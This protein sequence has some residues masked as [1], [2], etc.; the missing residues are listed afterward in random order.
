MGGLLIWALLGLNI[1]FLDSAILKINRISNVEVFAV[2]KPRKTADWVSKPTIRVCE[3]SEVPIFR[4]NQAVKY[5]NR[6]G[7]EFDGIFLDP[8][9]SCMNPKYGEIVITLPE[10]GFSSQHMAST[11]LYTMISS[12]VIVKAKIHILPKYARK[13]R[14]LEHEI[15]HALGW[16]HHSKRYHIMHPY[17]EM[18]GYD[19]QGL[20]Q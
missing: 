19:S 18:S 15:G 12:D 10:R 5:W 9:P 14:V 20:K 4:V 6:L 7:Y 3:S 16:K 11:R 8:S 17:W 1:Q 2:G 13:E